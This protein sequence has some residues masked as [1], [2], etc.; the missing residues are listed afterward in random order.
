[1]K[2]GKLN[3]SLL[4]AILALVLV[5]SSLTAYAVV[6]FSFRVNGNTNGNTDTIGS[7]VISA[8][9][10]Q[11]TLDFTTPG[12]KIDLPLTVKSTAKTNVTYNFGLSVAATDGS[13]V[14]S[15]ELTRLSSAILVYLDGDFCGTLA[16]LT[17]NG[18]A[19]LGTNYL[20]G[21]GTEHTRT[22]TWQFELHIATEAALLGKNIDVKIAT[23]ISSVDYTKYMFVSN[24]DDFVKA[25]DD[26]NSGLVDKTQTIVLA[27]DVTLSQAVEFA[28]PVN[29]ELN[30]NTLTLGANITLSGEGMYTLS[31]CN[32][33]SNSPNVGGG[34][35]LLDGEKAALD[36]ADF[37]SFDGTN[38][39]AQ[40]SANTQA[41]KYSA[42]LVYN[43]LQTRMPTNLAD[44]VQSGDAIDPFGALGF[45]KNA[46]NVAVVG[47]CTYADGVIT[48]NNVTATSQTSVTVTV[49]AQSFTCGLRVVGGDNATTLQSLLANEL[50]HIP[51]STT[52]D[53]VTYDVF[54]PKYI[55]GKNMRIE[56]ASSD[57]D[58]ISAD[59]KLADVLKENTTVTLYATIYVNDGVYA[60]TTFTFK[61][62]SQTRE[63]K[64]KYLVAQLSPIKLTKVYKGE[65][66]AYYYLP[67]VD[68]TNANDYRTKFTMYNND[69]SSVTWAAFRDIGLTNLTYT[70]KSG[71]NF[72]TFDSTA[73]AVYLNSATF[74]TF[75]QMTVT[76]DFGDGETYTE[77]VN[78][79]IELGSNSELYELV[80]SYV[81]KT[82]NDVDILQNMLDTRVMYGAK[83]ECGD[84]YLPAEYQGIAITCAPATAN[85]S[86][87]SAITK[88]TVKGEEM[89][90]VTV[91]PTKFASSE[92]SQGIKVT[93]K[94]DGDT[95]DGQNRVLY[96]VAPAVIKP[97]S[98]GFAN[99]SVFN[100]V[101]YQTVQKYSYTV[102]DTDK[103]EERIKALP[104][105]T[106]SEADNALDVSKRTGFVTNNDGTVTNTTAD[107]ILAVDV[108][109]VFE[110]KLYVGNDSG[111]SNSHNKAYQFAQLLAWA[112]GSDKANLPVTVTGYSG[113][114]TSEVKSDGKS[115][116]NTTE[117][118][119]LKAFLISD[120]GFTE[121]E[122]DTWW[123]KA[124]TTPENGR[125]ID[126]YTKITELAASM[127]LSNGMNYFKY[128]ELLQWALNEKDF[129]GIAAGGNNQD[130]PP[131][132]GT[133]G[134][135]NIDMSG[136]KG[137]TSTTLDWT[138]NPS[139]WTVSAINSSAWDRY[140]QSKYYTQSTVYV[141]DHTEYISDA[142][143]Q[144]IM[145]FW[146]GISTQTNAKA[147]AQ[148][149]LNACIIPTYLHEDGAGI[150]VNAIYG[151]LREKET[152]GFTVAM[153]DGVPQVSILDYSVEGVN[154]YLGLTS[155]VASGSVSSNK[156]VLPAFITTSSV[157]GCFN[158]VTKLDADR[159]ETKLTKFVMKACTS[160][161]TTLDLTTLSRLTD[162]AHMDFS[163]NS[164]ISSIGDVLNLDIK[165]ISYL[166][167]YGVDVHGKYLTYVL[168]NIK[169]NNTG[170]T[171][172]YRNNENER[173]AYAATSTSTSDE[174]R[175][176][177]ELTK[178]DSPYLLLANKLNAGNGDKTVQW[179]VNEGNPAYLIDDAGI[180]K[181]D[182]VATAE[183]MGMLMSNYY[184]CTNDVTVKYKDVTYNLQKNNVYKISYIDGTNPQFVFTK[185]GT[186]LDGVV[187]ETPDV[188]NI[189]WTVAT[190]EKKQTSEQIS[191]TNDAD[192]IY[193]SLTFGNLK[194]ESDDNNY[195]TIVPLTSYG[196][197]GYKAT[198]LYF[199]NSSMPVY[200]VYSIKKTVKVEYVYRFYP[201]GVRCITK[202]YLKGNSV[203]DVEYTE[204]DYL[205][206]S[207]TEYR[208]Y[209]LYFAH[210]SNS[211]VST[212]TNLSQILNSSI[213]TSSNTQSDFESFRVG[214]TSGTKYV[215][216]ENG[217]AIYSVSDNGC[218][219][220]FSTDTTFSGSSVSDVKASMENE[221]SKL[222]STDS[223]YI[224]NIK[225]DKSYT[226]NTFI[227]YT[228]PIVSTSDLT[229]AMDKATAAMDR[230]NYVLYK[231]TGT[232]VTDSPY[233]VEG[234]SRLMS[235]TQNQGYRLRFT[236]GS[237]STAGYSFTT[238]SLVENAAAINMQAILTEANQHIN[239]GLFGNYYGNYYCYN[240][241]TRTIGNVTYTNGYVYRL[242]LKA[243]R[244][245]FYFEHDNLPD[246]RKTFTSYGTSSALVSE[247]VK[248]LNKSSGC[249]S[250]GAIV[251]YRADNGDKDA[252]YAKGLYELT[253][254]SSTK[255][256]YFKSMGGLGNQ[257]M[258][259]TKDSSGNE[260][261]ATFLL[262]SIVGQNLSASGISKFTNIR[263]IGTT[264]SSFYSGTGG[265][266][267]VEIV[268][269]IVD[270]DTVYERYFLV[271]VSA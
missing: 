210:T 127:S 96:V 218:T 215:Y 213:G 93:V 71:Y 69:N 82:I 257:N 220:S 256:Y 3:Q 259:I 263:Y 206:F 101:K 160:G 170:A 132:L 88:E 167:V 90:R 141:E 203:I 19:K 197:W 204:S 200:A 73:Q 57:P 40:Y 112:T 202:H 179:Y 183:A 2:I 34:K 126:D 63:T 50:K 124:T 123:A 190:V 188:N 166:D 217:H 12:K 39:G 136:G 232:T 102:D 84:F 181:F 143:A 191:A 121:A 131:N 27:D 103:L 246:E 266:E 36:I 208:T 109:R 64:F 100:S 116:M 17:A 249:L 255:I 184:A 176:L 72:I 24:S 224:A 30:G 222:T 77:N 128:T 158:R 133:I 1:M 65:T 233:V 38:I 4:V 15:D 7:S 61:V 173:T 193:T 216:R 80:F 43:L 171:I 250:K 267:Q 32:K 81:E 52:I 98:D 164:G 59:G 29:I 92:S 168:E 157:N 119:V 91:D 153:T 180:D 139:N 268:A 110:L 111:A 125:V 144:C 223:A 28:N 152:I 46:A 9:M 244:S 20:V 155:F 41:V 56:W 66:D 25:A 18:E 261:A 161:Y 178:V 186:T 240:G 262:N 135:N 192:P 207:V 227:T 105:V 271:T 55:E 211:N 196:W 238:I 185:I 205:E 47:D 165:K 83:Y 106:V 13:S 212:N 51:N 95:S 154:S 118:A 21:S 35:I 108:N 228:N 6:L 269:R 243:D 53:A 159:T 265:S 138:S 156:V 113:T 169:V 67:V 147:Y 241:N 48:A 229:N 130:S 199:G 174:L 68:S 137:V 75:A 201:N 26:T 140:K 162:V 94:K 142:E 146:F 115:Y 226:E 236:V 62:T 37:T 163:Y 264:S 252:F 70:V 245:G 76:G 230:N 99:Y 22:H 89:W 31:S 8:E 145:A 16:S 87:I 239:D 5:V 97:D 60:T 172:Y 10:T 33:L 58:S 85:G 258:D 177:N 150:L 198:Q 251:Y 195:S 45:Y 248:A 270:G 78:V 209:T 79:I 14:T 182:T 237:G 253:Y 148:A 189:D 44:G 187:T 231:Y 122:Y 247:L 214:S 54:L 235:C 175:F 42:E 120:V 225:S 117:T 114:A 260:A 151:K 254:N 86:G 11:T 104:T 219:A 194:T 49:W 234:E 129:D 221:L 149:F 74:Y 107:Y 134:L 242:L 23:Y